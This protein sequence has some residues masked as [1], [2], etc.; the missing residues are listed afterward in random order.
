[1]HV[2]KVAIQAST[3]TP[4][5][6]LARL[7]ITVVQPEEPPPKKVDTVLFWHPGIR[8]DL[9]DEEGMLEGE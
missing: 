9:V 1:M 2:S 3:R 4:P 7:A 6:L 8:A 5:S